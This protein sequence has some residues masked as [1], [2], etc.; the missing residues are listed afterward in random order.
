[1]RDAVATRLSAEDPERF[2]RYRIAAWRQLQSEVHS[3]P[4]SALWR[5]TADILY[6][7]QKPEVRE[8]FFPTG[9]QVLAVESATTS[10]KND[11][12]EIAS[13]HEGREGT[14][15]I[16][17]WWKHLPG[18]FRVCINATG[19]VSGFAI[20][21]SADH[22]PEDVITS[23]PIVA[24]WKGIL[25]SS[26]RPNQAIF[27]RR[28]L[29]REEGEAASPSRGAFGL[30]VKRAYMEMRPSL[31]FVYL[32]GNDPVQ[33]EWCDPLGFEEQESAFAKLD[34]KPF[35]TYRLDMGP[36]SVDAWLQRLVTAE[37]GIE[38]SASEPLLD[39]VGHELHTVNGRVPLSPLEY[40][41]VS[42]LASRN[43]KPVSRA[44]L[45]EQ[46]WGYRGD[47]SS[48]VVDAVVLSLRKKLGPDAHRLETV[49]GVGYRLR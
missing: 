44:D 39:F 6:F 31:R 9:H 11:I 19:H 16:A 29:D 42:L 12:F 36:G 2:R 34:D 46:V 41:V 47:A 17:T 18:A 25:P 32:G 13:R 7:L 23:D 24:A 37:L 5:Y 28:L 3:A 22:V 8:G 21:T 10:H 4:A 48:N 30:D 49:R 14:D 35:H 43:G 40:G 1:M 33:F 26:I 38:E 15:I 20:A 27:I 45:V